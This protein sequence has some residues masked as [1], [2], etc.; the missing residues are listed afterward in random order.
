MTK[1]HNAKLLFGRQSVV[2]SAT[3]SKLSGWD[4]LIIGEEN[5]NTWPQQNLMEQLQVS[6]LSTVLVRT[7]SDTHSPPIPSFF[8]RAQACGWT[9]RLGIPLWKVG[10]V[11]ESKD[12]TVI[13]ARAQEV[14]ET[15]KSSIIFLSE[16][17]YDVVKQNTAETQLLRAAL[18]CHGENEG[19]RIVPVMLPPFS[20]FY[21][22]SAVGR[23]N[24]LI[25]D[26]VVDP[27]QGA[28][29]ER[30][31]TFWR[32]SVMTGED[33]GQF[34]QKVHE[35]LLGILK[36]GPFGTPEERRE[37]FSPIAEKTRSSSEGFLGESDVGHP[38]VGL[39]SKLV[40]SAS[41]GGVSYAGA[42]ASFASDEEML[43][44]PT[45]PSDPVEHFFAKLSLANVAT[46]KMQ[47][48]P[49]VDYVKVLMVSEQEMWRLIGEFALRL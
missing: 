2:E 40:S 35:K 49:L 17:F 15:C 4:V 37:F 21:H 9:V 12:P 45:K 14:A 1:L 20:I 46:H 44:S 34:A 48:I 10:E 30:L 26:E 29:G 32:N 19:S 33:P 23:R 8:Y 7:S 42:D 39:F 38:V 16:G 28:Y 43:E 36:D 41:V 3:Y 24:S 31:K 22:N 27:W 47:E 18:R 6:S 5:N 11:G 25:D 13:T